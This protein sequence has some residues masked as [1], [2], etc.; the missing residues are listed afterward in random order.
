MNLIFPNQNTHYS[1]KYQKK[2]NL[3]LFA[4]ILIEKIPDATNAQ[5]NYI[6]CVLHI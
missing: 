6:Y 1:M 2:T 3:L 5:Q 4:T